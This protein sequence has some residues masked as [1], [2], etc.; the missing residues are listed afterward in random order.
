LLENIVISTKIYR[1]AKQYLIVCAFWAANSCWG[2]GYSNMSVC[3][4]DNVL[5][6]LL[7]LMI[8]KK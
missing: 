3:V 5:E 8:W 2:K 4:E 1:D 7:T 6:E